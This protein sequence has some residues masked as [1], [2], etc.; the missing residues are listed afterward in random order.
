L[1]RSEYDHAAPLLDAHF[2]ENVDAVVQLASQGKHVLP[3][4][5]PT[6]ARGFI[7]P[8]LF[9]DRVRQHLAVGATT[10]VKVQANALLRLAIDVDAN[11]IQAAR[12]LP[13]VPL[14]EALRYALGDDL[15]R[16][17]DSILFAAA[18]R[19]RR[20]RSGAAR[21]Y[22]WF[23]RSVT[24]EHFAAGYLRIDFRVIETVEERTPDPV[25]AMEHSTAATDER[26]W[27]SR[28]TVAR[29]RE[30][31]IRYH[32]TLVPSDLEPFFADGADGVCHRIGLSDTHDAAYLRPLI[33]PTVPMKPIA[34]MLLLAALSSAKQDQAVIAVDALVHAHAQGRLDLP[35]LGSTMRDLVR[36]Y[37]V[38][39]ARLVKSFRAA[40]RADETLAPTIVAMIFDI[41]AASPGPV[42]DATAVLELLQELLVGNGM[43]VSAEQQSV[44]ATARLGS[45]AASIRK[46]LL[47]DAVRQ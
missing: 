46:R 8:S 31:N 13:H 7:D 45:K 40:L 16:P 4:T 35:L 42:E 27:H 2:V 25:A 29:D 22:E 26:G 38:K 11:A 17:R 10:P 15:D 36:S 30:H 43:S 44:M 14:T 39:N 9:V 20:Q 23:A 18:E 19:I 24:G 5:T 1:G 47:S 32:A 12:T 41:L 37:L 21:R 28:P 3:L 34:S 33:D 6:H